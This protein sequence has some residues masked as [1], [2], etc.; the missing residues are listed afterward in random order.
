[1]T[2]RFDMKS[3]PKIA[4]L[5]KQLDSQGMLGAEAGRRI[6][7]SALDRLRPVVSWPGFRAHGI[8]EI[9]L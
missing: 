1:M 5:P 6:R 4:A 7:S 3:V 9:C 8:K 2:A